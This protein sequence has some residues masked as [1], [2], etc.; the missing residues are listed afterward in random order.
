MN[1]DKLRAKL[2]IIL[3]LISSVPLVF[4]A[5]V[6]YKKE[7]ELVRK[8]VLS[9]LETIVVQDT[10]MI[11]EFR[12][13]RTHDLNLLAVTIKG[14]STEK[15]VEHFR[16][17]QKE[18]KIYKHIFITNQKGI[19]LCEAG[20]FTISKKNLAAQEWSKSAMSGNP[21]MGDIGFYN[22]RG[23]YDLLVAV[24]VK[25]A[26][27]RITGVL[28]ATINFQHI[29][30]IMKST[31]IGRTGEIYLVNK[32]GIFLTATR[33][34]T[35]LKGKRLM[36]ERFAHYFTAVGPDEYI[37]YRGKRVVRAFRKLPDLDWFLVGEQD[38]DEVFKDITA[39]R[40]LFAGFSALL[41]ALIALAG[42][43]I[44]T[45]M[46]RLLEVAYKQ[47]KDLEMQVIQKDKLASMGLLTGGI[48]HEL[49]TPLAGALLYTQMLKEEVKDTTPSHMEKLVFV[50]EEIKRSSRIVRSL[51]D[52][53]RQSQ[54]DS[55][56][57][58]VNEI[59]SK[60]LDISDKLC[61]D[62][63]IEVKR[64]FEAGVPLVKG[65]GSILHQVFMNIVANAIE[66]MEDGGIL[67]VAT[68]HAQPLHKVVI[69]IQDTGSGIPEEFLGDV[70][71]P[72]FTTKSSGEGVGL[73]LALS[74]SMVR[75]MGGNIR[76]TSSF[77]EENTISKFPSGTTFTIELPAQE[78]ELHDHES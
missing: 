9:H 25:S 42:Y 23:D 55:D 45:K 21:F 54:T 13:E 24:P 10:L 7:V 52:F 61:S 16:L 50:E 3:V 33:I 56:V 57:A 8:K 36:P 78:K 27:G 40:T 47:N 5:A 22:A 51:L 6:V 35:G 63:R 71:D 32:N 59:L 44:S 28:G 65:N 30:D 4:F 62:K 39:L 2:I 67:T 34:G 77:N 58:D 18:R 60:L 20:S 26:T 19:V 41:I 37:D 70:F 11:D 73:G 66:A 48:A 43:F 75:K 31:G 49:N 72:F 14:L 68:R 46:V 74:Y 38:S 12:K 53:S 17:M 15:A 76:V 1:F 69:D 64:S 29:A